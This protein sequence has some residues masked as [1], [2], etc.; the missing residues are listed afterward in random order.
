AP[1]RTAPN[2]PAMKRLLVVAVLLL[3]TACSP[4]PTTN[5]VLIAYGQT[6]SGTLGSA[7]FHFVFVGDMGDAVDVECS[8]ASGPLL[9]IVLDPKNNVLAQ[10]SGAVTLPETGQYTIVI[11]AGT[12]NFTLRLRLLRSGKATLRPRVTATPLESAAPVTGPTAT[13]VESAIPP[14]QTPIPRTPAPVPTLLPIVSTATLASTGLSPTAAFGPVVGG[15]T[16]TDLPSLTASFLPTTPEPGITV[17]SN[18]VTSTFTPTF[19]PVTAAGVGSQIH[20]GETLRGKIGSPE[21]IDRYIFFSP[22]QT[23]VTIGMF[24]VAVGLIPAFEMY[25]PD[26]SRVAAVAG[27]ASLP[28]AVYSGYILPQTGAYIIYPHSAG[29]TGNYDLT[30]GANWTLREIGGGE[31]TPN[32]IHNGNILRVGD[33]ETWT[34]TLQTNSVITV[35]AVPNNSQEDPVIEIIDPNGFRI[36]TGHD[37]SL[38]NHAR[39]E[40]LRVP[41]Q[42]VYK[43]RI[44]SYA[45]HTIG[46]YTVVVRLVG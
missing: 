22:A 24:P 46:G 32:I 39:V 10:A 17:V 25:A 31:L 15:P 34:I 36:A 19:L 40:N 23:I 16:L 2:M 30:I 9:I 28:Q 12:G 43:I 35:E 20:V 14:S 3:L 1:Y 27:T 5:L 33:R 45:N 26:G 41:S 44:T 42:G 6:M 18:S 11:P 4:T 37:F 29:G 13:R 7:D 21:Q 38:A 8:T